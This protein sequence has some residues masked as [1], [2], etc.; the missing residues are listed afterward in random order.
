MLLPTR[1]LWLA[2]AG[3]AAVGSGWPVPGLA[4]AGAAVFLFV[5]DGL[6]GR[7]TMARGLTVRPVAPRRIAQD[8]EA[9]LAVELENRTGQDLRVRLAVDGSTEL[10]TERTWEAVEASVTDGGRA[11]VA[12]ELVGR[13]RGRRRLER[14]WLRATGRLG[15]A[16]VQRKL[17]L[18]HEVEVVP[19]LRELRENRL[20]AWH[21]LPHLT[22]SRAVRQRGDSGAFESLREY[23]RGDDP[24]RID[25]KA[26][27]R[28]RHPIVRHYE[29]E[30]A[31]NLVLCIDAGRH[32]S[33]AFEGRERLDHALASAVVLADVAR[34]WND[35]VGVLAFAD[36]IQAFLPPAHHEPD[37]ILRLAMDVQ[38]RRAES[39]YPRA[40]VTLSR[41]ITR[42]S[43]LVFF[44]DVI[45]E[46]VSA[47]L[48]QHVALLA[49]RHLP[50]FVAMKN[51][52]LVAAA[53]AEV[54]DEPA[55]YRRAAASELVL[56][57]E[58]TLRAMR[59]AGIGVVD[60]LPTASMEAVVNRYVEIKR[61]GTL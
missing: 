33:E 48:T 54:A 45:D 10:A 36:G 50:L 21:H 55:A 28:R 44:S 61:R 20:L 11:R 4:G 22:G 9:E 51:P 19:G 59:Q 14:L 40:L 49:R 60:A 13:R 53:N 5:F 18:D 8:E 34:A 46:A 38:A 58:R 3:A 43:L 7:R 23:A 27:A 47:P 25:W 52:E 32:M 24:R 56:A 37:R 31:Q 15:L 6:V 12:F 42:R 26:T 16:W 17:P 2:L 29:A 57:R 1:R 41:K 35:K 30:R 39:D